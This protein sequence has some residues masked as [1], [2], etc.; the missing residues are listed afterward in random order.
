MKNY[1]MPEV[2]ELGTADALVLG[3]IPSSEKD[4][5]QQQEFLYVQ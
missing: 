2:V 1:E 4:N 5:P 3:A